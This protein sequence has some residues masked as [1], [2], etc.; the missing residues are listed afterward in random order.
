IMEDLDYL[1]NKNLQKGKSKKEESTQATLIDPP[2]VNSCIKGKIGDAVRNKQMEECLRKFQEVTGIAIDFEYVDY[3]RPHKK[4]ELKNE[5]GI[6]I[7]SLGSGYEMFFSI[8]YGYILAKRSKEQIIFL[9]DEPE[10]HLHP[11]LQEELIK[12]LLEA[13]KETQVVLSSHST[14]IVEQLI[15]AGFQNFKILEKKNNEVIEVKQLQA[16]KL[17]TITSAEVNFIAF[18]RCTAEYQNLLYDRARDLANC[19][20]HT[21]FSNWILSKD[22]SRKQVAWTKSTSVP[23][24][25]LVIDVCLRHLFHYPSNLSLNGCDINSEIKDS[26]IFL[27][28]LL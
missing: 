11:S 8:L 10:M 21:A 15:A 18:D 13:S 6:D 14:L 20:G 26:I 28:S 24:Q 1:Y 27:R 4:V 22:K 25:Q 17:P 5:E 2:D 23:P 19:N 12:F 3:Y 9:I 16:Q 7:Q